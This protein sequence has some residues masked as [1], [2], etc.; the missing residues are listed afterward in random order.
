MNGWRASANG[1]LAR[2]DEVACTSQV[3][4]AIADAIAMPD[5]ATLAEATGHAQPHPTC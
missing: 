1:E 3:G 5:T 2:V 4:N